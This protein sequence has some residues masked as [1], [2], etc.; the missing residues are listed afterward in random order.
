MHDGAD[1]HG[2]KV[3]DVIGLFFDGEVWPTERLLDDADF[4]A[5]GIPFGV[6][7]DFEH[8]GKD[9]GCWGGDFG[10]GAGLKDGIF[11]GNGGRAEA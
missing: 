3:V 5:E 10:G 2:G 11:A 9:L 6:V 4:G 8:G 1:P 7:G